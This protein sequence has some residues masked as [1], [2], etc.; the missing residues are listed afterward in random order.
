M[1]NLLRVYDLARLAGI[2]PRAIARPALF[3]SGSVA[4]NI[5]ID[6]MIR[7]E[8]TIRPPTPVVLGQRR[9]NAV[10]PILLLEFEGD[11]G[12]MLVP[13]AL[14]P[15]QH[16]R[17]VGQ[18]DHGGIGYGEVDLAVAVGVVEYVL[19][20]RVHLYLLRDAT[21]DGIVAVH[22]D[23]ENSVVREMESDVGV[24]GGAANALQ[25]FAH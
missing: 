25:D 24:R 2:A 19:E 6:V 12:M 17:F 13:P 21:V 1:C 22:E 11:C 7:A 20:V 23:L 9:P 4:R 18:R 10:P 14:L 3:A 8:H 16:V 15:A 5:K